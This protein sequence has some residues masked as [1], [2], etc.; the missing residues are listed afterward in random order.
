MDEQGVKEREGK[1]EAELRW[2]R[3]H[4]GVREGLNLTSPF[5]LPTP[6]RDKVRG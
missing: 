1:G 4:Y 3:P 6:N 2:T 5:S